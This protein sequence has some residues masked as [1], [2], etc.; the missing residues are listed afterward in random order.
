MELETEFPYLQQSHNFSFRKLYETYS[1]S[2][3]RFVVKK[4]RVR[5]HI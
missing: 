1:E 3:Y 4:N 2:K 5:F